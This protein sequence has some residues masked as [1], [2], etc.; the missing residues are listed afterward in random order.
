MKN[1]FVKVILAVIAFASVAQAESLTS[2]ISIRPLQA[3]LK[4]AIGVKGVK[5]GL[6]LNGGKAVEEAIYITG[7]AAKSVIATANSIAKTTKGAVKYTFNEATQMVVLTGRT[8]KELIKQYGEKALTTG[9]TAIDFAVANGQAFVYETQ[10]LA[11]YATA[12]AILA[13]SDAAKCAAAHVKSFYGE[14]KLVAYETAETAKDAA[15]TVAQ[16][17]HTALEKSLEIAIDFKNAAQAFAQATVIFVNDAGLFVY[18]NTK[19]ALYK[20]GD[21]SA[22]GY[23]FLKE[24]FLITKDALEALGPA[25]LD[26]IATVYNALPSVRVEIRF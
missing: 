4:T 22:E 1:L 18:D 12:Y 23:K 26:G 19:A 10:S 6:E 24:G 15:N 20:I 16:A 14:V 21:I 9:Q 13:L 11:R 8:A 3:A 5:I 17:L 2:E 25:I 7:E